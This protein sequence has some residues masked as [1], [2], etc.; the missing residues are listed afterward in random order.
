M[1]RRAH[2]P[3]RH[4]SRQSRD[5]SRGSTWKKANSDHGTLN[6]DAA[7]LLTVSDMSDLETKVKVDETDVSRIN[8]ATRVVQLDAFLIRHSRL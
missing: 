7:T 5:A 4:W 1:T 2:S 8:S 6:K 3:K